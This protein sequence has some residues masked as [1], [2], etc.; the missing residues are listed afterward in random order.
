MVCLIDCFWH[1]EFSV[2]KG[3]TLLPYIFDETVRILIMPRLL[4]HR[5]IEDSV[6]VPKAN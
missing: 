1:K 6:M 4:L 2:T 3:G 5:R